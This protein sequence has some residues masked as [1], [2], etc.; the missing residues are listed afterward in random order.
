[1]DIKDRMPRRRIHPGRKTRSWRER[2]HSRRGMTLVEV[3]VVIAIILTLMG[4]V[5]YGVMQVWENSRVETTKLQMGR[6][7]ERVQ[8]Y[9]VKHKKPPTSGEGL[10]VVYGDAAV[11]RDAWDNEFIYLSPGPDGS[12]YDL[13]SYGRDGVEGGT[14]LAEDIHLSDMLN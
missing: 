13:I 9:H 3:M 7:I 8:I 4:I 10:A 2:L 11:P 6:M 1:M 5:G 12:D 14:G